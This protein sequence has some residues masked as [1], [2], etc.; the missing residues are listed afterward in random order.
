[1]KKNRNLKIKKAL[2]ILKSIEKVRAKNNKNWMEFVKLSL[3]LDYDKTV[4]LI[5]KIYKYDTAISKLA[6]KIYK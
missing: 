6:K 5:K 3:T 4:G 2:K 1:M